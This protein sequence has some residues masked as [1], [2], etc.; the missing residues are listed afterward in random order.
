MYQA[1]ERGRGRWYLFSPED[2]GREQANARVLWSERITEALI[3]DRFEL[4]FQPIMELATGSMQRREAL[5]RMSD[6]Q[7]QLVYPNHF[8]PVAEKTGQIHAIDHWVLARSILVLQMHPGIDLS[9]NLS[10]NAMEDPSLLPD[11]KDLCQT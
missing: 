11:L 6:V 5:L 10:A 7:G 8:I 1:K 4:H 9:V 3:E 2:Q